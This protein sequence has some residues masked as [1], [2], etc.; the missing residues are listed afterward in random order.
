MPDEQQ[1]VNQLRDE[2]FLH[3]ALSHVEACH[4]LTE[5]C[6]QASMQAPFA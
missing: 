5:R 1:L 3:A 6:V 4:M 2:L